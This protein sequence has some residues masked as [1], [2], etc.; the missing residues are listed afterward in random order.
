MKYRFTI[1]VHSLRPLSNFINS[2]CFHQSLCF[3]L[4]EVLPFSSSFCS[5]RSGLLPEDHF[6]PFLIWMKF[7]V[8]MMGLEV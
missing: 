5:F 3:L 4:L 8:L 6:V 2:F 1:N 7:F